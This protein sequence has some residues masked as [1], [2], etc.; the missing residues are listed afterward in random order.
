MELISCGHLG[1]GSSGVLFYSAEC[2][3]GI[4][5][6]QIMGSSSKIAFYLLVRSSSDFFSDVP[7]L[8]YLVRKV[9]VKKK[10]TRYICLLLSD[11]ANIQ[12]TRYT[13]H[14]LKKSAG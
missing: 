6:L 13:I 9:K 3:Q 5:R 14:P 4:P 2:S 10:N 1:L 12:A 8:R 7:T 11:K